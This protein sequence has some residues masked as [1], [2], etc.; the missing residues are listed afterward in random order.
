[1]ENIKLFEN[2]DSEALVRYIGTLNDISDTA[3]L[4]RNHFLLKKLSQLLSEQNIAHEYIGNK[5]KM[6]KSE[7]FIRFHAFLK[8]IVNQH[9]SISFLLIKDYLGVTGEEYGEIRS[10]YTTGGKGS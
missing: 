10:Y 8:L 3:V 5:S 7:G 1:M 2:M 4:S 9:D 6:V